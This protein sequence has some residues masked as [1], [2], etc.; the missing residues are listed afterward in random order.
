MCRNY[1][2]VY[3]WR[4]YANKVIYIAKVPNFASFLKHKKI[5]LDNEYFMQAWQYKSNFHNLT[6]ASLY[7][8]RWNNRNKERYCTNPWNSLPRPRYLKS[9]IQLGKLI[10]WIANEIN[11]MWKHQIMIIIKILSYFIEFKNF[12]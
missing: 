3:S 1:V 10:E 7:R 5:Y 2:N 4:T 8:G 6:K 9:R 11:G 12:L